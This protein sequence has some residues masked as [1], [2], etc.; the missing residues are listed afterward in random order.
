MSDKTSDN[1]EIL[2]DKEVVDFVCHSRKLSS[3]LTPEDIDVLSQLSF[4]VTVKGKNKV[5]TRTRYGSHVCPGIRSVI[6]AVEFVKASHGRSLDTLAD[7]EALCKDLDFGSKPKGDPSTVP[8]AKR[9]RDVSGTNGTPGTNGTNGVRSSQQTTTQLRGEAASLARIAYAAFEESGD[10]DEIYAKHASIDRH[11]V[12]SAF[13][14]GRN[15]VK[16]RLPNP[17]N[18]DA[19]ITPGW[20]DS[21]LQNEIAIKDEN[22]GLDNEIEEEQGKSGDGD[23]GDDKS[24]DDGNDKSDDGNEA[25]DEAEERPIKKQKQRSPL[26]DLDYIKFKK[27]VERIVGILRHCDG[28][29]HEM[30]P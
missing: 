26:E 1:H 28:D 15:C 16:L 12:K 30:R 23:D 3:A 27:L 14:L 11:A 17:F 19:C 18:K 8:T 9:G 4:H 24:G 5:I 21:F 29:V 20:F 2:Q 22:E 6:R 25:K 7:V 13:L 10:I